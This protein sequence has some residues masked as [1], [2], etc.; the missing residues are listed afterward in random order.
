MKKG[1]LWLAVL[2]LALGGSTSALAFETPCIAQPY[3]WQYEDETRSI[4]IDRVS[5][6]TVTY[7]A[8]D[9]QLSAVSLFQTAVSDNLSPVSALASQAG[10][11]LAINGDDCGTHSFGIIIRNGSLLRAKQ[12]T[13]NLLILD[14][15]GNMS[16]KVDRKDEN[17]KSLGNELLASG[18]WQTFEFGPELVRD[19]Q[20]VTF[21]P[22]FDVISTREGRLE[23]RTAI[24]QIGPLHYL[25]LVVDGRQEGYS[26]GISLQDLQQLFLQYGAQTAMNL[27]GGGSAEMWFQGQVLNRPSGGEERSVSDIIF[28]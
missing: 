26:S 28:F 20:A 23:P 1:L 25:L 2:L 5:D 21:S 15:E 7:Y 11:V 14:A 10:A 12:T 18:A 13:R 16:V 4:A 6:G 24:G 27:D 22:T 3:Q 8:A 19:E 9:V 17:A